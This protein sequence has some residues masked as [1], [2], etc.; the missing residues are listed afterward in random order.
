MITKINQQ[1]KLGSLRWFDIQ[2]VLEVDLV[3]WKSAEQTGKVYT[4]P[5]QSDLSFN[6]I[7]VVRI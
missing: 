5:D 6:L 3:F 2:L 7:D 4:G 1:N